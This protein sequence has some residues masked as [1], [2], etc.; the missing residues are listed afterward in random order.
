[1]HE[2]TPTTSA[3]R[4]E[5][6]R[7]E[8]RRDILDA[9]EALLVESGAEAFSMRR[10]ASRCGFAAP[11]LYHYF[12][13][14]QS[15]FDALVEARLRPLVERARRRVREDDPVGSIRAIVLEFV[16]FG[17][18]NPGHYRVLTISR[19]PD[20]SPPP[21]AAEESRALLEA[22]LAKLAAGGRL[23]A[24]RIEHAVQYLWITL[25]GL[26]SLHATRTDIKW[27]EGIVDFTLDAALA[28]LLRAGPETA[29]REIG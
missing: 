5:A 17:L 18:E 28:G 16:R 27:A 9:A 6:Q 29:R 15:L 13:D 25:H 19:A 10:L 12:G 2:G 1:M 24:D 23:A 4:R 3:E 20:G 11:S 14:R 22:P 8:A 26:V 21:A 7:E